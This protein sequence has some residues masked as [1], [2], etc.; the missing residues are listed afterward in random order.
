[1]VS[2]NSECSIKDWHFLTL[3]SE[4]LVD[5]APM[6]PNTQF[7]VVSSRC[8]SHASRLP[9]T[10]ER[11]FRVARSCLGSVAAS[12]S[13]HTPPSSYIGCTCSLHAVSSALIA[14][15]IA[16]ER[17]R[18]NEKKSRLQHPPADHL[19]N[20]SPPIGHAPNHCL[21]LFQPPLNT[22]K[23]RTSLQAFRPQ[24]TAMKIRGNHT[25]QLVA[26]DAANRVFGA[27]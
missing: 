1:M 14:Y 16:L 12:R 5:F 21:R 19:T 6:M 20:P 26:D 22:S 15:F 2:G 10:T 11:V 24:E 27:P 13:S 7:T 8:C 23:P 17:E 4:L 9:P 3:S 25:L 18:Q